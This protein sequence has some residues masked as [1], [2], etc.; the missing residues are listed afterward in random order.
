[1]APTRRTAAGG[2]GGG[3]GAG[4]GGGGGRG[5]VASPLALA[6]LVLLL[7]AGFVPSAQALI[8]KTKFKARQDGSGAFKIITYDLFGFKEGGTLYFDMA[9]VRGSFCLY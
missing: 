9:C 2:G 4:G 7:C 6:L 8:T 1:M 5:G 3:G